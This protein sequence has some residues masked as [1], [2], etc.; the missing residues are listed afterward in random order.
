MREV[1][2]TFIE[3]SFD[4]E[5]RQLGEACAQHELRRDAKAPGTFLAAFDAYHGPTVKVGYY[6]RKWLGL[7]CNAVKRGFVVDPSITPDVLREMTGKICP[8]SLIPFVMTGKSPANPSVDRLLNDGVYALGNL[9][10]FSQRVNRAKGDKSFEEVS[11]IAQRGESADGL[12]FIEWARLASLMYGG[13]CTAGRESRFI[14]PLAV[15]PPKHVF[16]PTSQVVQLL[17]MRW[18]GDKRYDENQRELLLSSMRS[19]SPSAEVEDLFDKLVDRLGPALRSEKHAPNT[20][21]RPKVFDAFLS[22]YEASQDEV[23]SMLKSS[24]ERLQSGVD[25]DLIVSNWRLDR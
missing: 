7:R 22:W 5:C 23:E 10:V 8:V 13:W 17:L 2:A 11:A 19:C 4:D 15:V 12:Q 25:R 1:M 9:A 16:T 3:T 20:W 21:L 18:C 14:V 6:V 24:H